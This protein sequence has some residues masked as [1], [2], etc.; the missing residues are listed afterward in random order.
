VRVPAGEDPRRAFADWLVSPRNPWF[1]RAAVNRVWAWIF[2]RGIVQEADDMR[3]DTPPSVPGL[4]EYLAKELVASRWD[5][6][7][8]YRL[9]LRSRTYQQSPIPRDDVVAV[10]P[11]FACYPVRRLDAEVLIDALCWLGGSGETYRS[12]T[13]E[14]F[15]FVPPENRTI[16]LADGSVTSPFLEMFGRPARDTGLLSERNNQF[17]DAQRLH[18]LNSTDVR[19]RIERSPRLRSVFDGAR[20]NQ[21]EMIRETWLTILSRY[22]TESEQDAAT[23]YFRV[24]GRWVRDAATDL[25]WALVNSREFLFRH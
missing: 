19:R 8:V 21:A 25:A 24:P 17:T 9:I 3:P 16:D 15:T 18:L 12:T 1:A 10:E 5:L 6:R 7:E 22:P 13:P 2:G 4:L 14:P 20:G 23:A 11:L